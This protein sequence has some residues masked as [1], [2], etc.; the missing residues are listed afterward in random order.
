MGKGA[1][2]H[3]QKR[4][5]IR[6]RAVDALDELVLRVALESEQLVPDFPCHNGGALLDR[7]ERVRAVHGRFTRSEKIE[8]RAVQ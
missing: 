3:D 2:V 6:A 1:R 8:V 5:P 4:H 7:L